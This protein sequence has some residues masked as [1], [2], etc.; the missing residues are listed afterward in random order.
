MV[1]RDTA[2]VRS[3]LR[4]WGRSLQLTGITP[5]FPESRR[6]VLLA[7]TVGKRQALADSSESNNVTYTTL[8]RL[9]HRVCEREACSDWFIWARGER[10]LVWGEPYNARL[11]NADINRK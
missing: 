9:D 3:G 2:L 7:A 8:H 6:S 5:D 10:E 11:N 4:D 1:S